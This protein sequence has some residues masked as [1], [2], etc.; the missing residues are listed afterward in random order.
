MLVAYHRWDSFK[1]S[2]K[3]IALLNSFSPF[4][5]YSFYGIDENAFDFIIIVKQTMSMQTFNK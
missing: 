1:T 4:C 2:A 5:F 3:I